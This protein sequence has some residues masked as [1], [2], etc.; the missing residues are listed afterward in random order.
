MGA[1]YKDEN[2]VINNWPWSCTI[3]LRPPFVFRTQFKIISRITF[4]T[5]TNKNNF[6]HVS[7]RPCV[8]GV[9]LGLLFMLCFYYETFLAQ[10]NI[11]PVFVYYRKYLR[12]VDRQVLAKR[13]FFFTVKVLEDNLD[14]LTGV[15]QLHS[16]FCVLCVLFIGDRSWRVALVACVSC[17]DSAMFGNW[18]SSQIWQPRVPLCLC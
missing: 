2:S 13:A 10:I 16:D 12:D 1:N 17:G 18:D 8:Y 15:W 9:M 7:G 6:Q 11:I 3:T 4:C 5:Q 14:K